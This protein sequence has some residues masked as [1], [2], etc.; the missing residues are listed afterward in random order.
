MPAT[1]RRVTSIV[2]L[3]DTSL[4]LPWPI[5]S[6]RPTPTAI[7]GTNEATG[8]STASAGTRRIT[9]AGMDKATPTAVQIQIGRQPTWPADPLAAASA[10]ALACAPIGSTVPMSDRLKTIDTLA[11]PPWGSVRDR[12]AMTSADDIGMAMTVAQKKAMR[13]F[14]TGRRARAVRCLNCASGR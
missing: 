3:N 8:Q 6:P 2:L 1:S 7:A 10:A 13:V 9:A 11:R 5:S 14:V 4:K 12:M